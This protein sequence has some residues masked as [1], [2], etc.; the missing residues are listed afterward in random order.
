[1]LAKLRLNQANKLP[2]IRYTLSMGI[3]KHP[4]D[5]KTFNDLFMIA[6]KALYIAKD[7]GKN[8]YIIYRP[9][10]H[11]SID[12]VGRQTETGIYPIYIKTLKNV[13]RELLVDG[14]ENIVRILGN[15]KEAFGLGAIAVHYGERFEHDIYAGECPESIRDIT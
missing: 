4:E 7:K 15:V 3:A 8:R 12:V 10:L 2:G 5:G 9:E 1:M 11:D 6:D 13:M 14:S